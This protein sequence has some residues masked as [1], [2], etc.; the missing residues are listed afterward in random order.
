MLPAVRV[1]EAH[2]VF[3]SFSGMNQFRCLGD[4]SRA[5]GTQ[6]PSMSRPDR[7]RYLY[8]YR[9][10]HPQKQFRVLIAQISIRSRLRPPFLV[11][12]VNSRGTGTNVENSLH[13]RTGVESAAAEIG[14]SPESGA[15]WSTFLQATPRWPPP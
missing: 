12:D 10:S 6:R 7:E 14:G 9:P 4:G 15:G 11:L 13:S 3:E 5:G 1:T 8:R 2:R